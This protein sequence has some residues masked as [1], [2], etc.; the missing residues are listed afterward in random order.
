M[1]EAD[2]PWTV[3]DRDLIARAMFLE[4]NEGSQVP[5]QDLWEDLRTHYEEQAEAALEALAHAGRIGEPEVVIKALVADRDRHAARAEQYRKGDLVAY[6]SPGE[7]SCG[8]P[9]P[10]G[11]QP[12]QRWPGHDAH[13]R[14]ASGGVDAWIQMP[15]RDYYESDEDPFE[16][17]SSFEAGVKGVTSP[18]SGHPCGHQWTETEPMDPHS[19]AELIQESG[20]SHVHRCC[21]NT[22]KEAE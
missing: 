20:Q 6:A 8:A 2:R 7:E 22:T 13:A 10:E 9:H 11:G 4:A 15:S 3:E 12:C 17:V 18:P 5:L 21:C 14:R 16:I 19:C 1:T